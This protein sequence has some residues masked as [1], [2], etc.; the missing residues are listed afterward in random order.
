MRPHAP[1][2]VR[3]LLFKSKSQAGNTLRM[4]PL[5]Q[6]PERCLPGSDTRNPI[7]IPPLLSQTQIHLLILVISPHRSLP[8]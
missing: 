3:E 6:V 2:P 7:P 8:S 4:V 5:L 1:P